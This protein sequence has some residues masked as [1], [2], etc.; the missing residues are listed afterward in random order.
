MKSSRLS[1][2]VAILALSTTV[3]CSFAA[4]QQKP[5]SI[6]YALHSAPSG[7]CPG[8]DW[9]VTV[10]GDNID[11]FVSVRH[12]DRIWR[13]EGKVEPAS[14]GKER[15]FEMEANEVGGAHRKAVVKGTSGG[16]YVNATITGAGT[17]CDGKTLAI[18]RAVNGVEGGA[19]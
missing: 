16:E 11:G 14:A 2:G 7:A 4:A 5:R 13:L 18:P 15:S 6:L 1:A 3:V 17:A 12:T 8:L 19:G 10:T 9:H